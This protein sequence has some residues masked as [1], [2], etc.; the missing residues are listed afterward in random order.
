MGR[1]ALGHQ[2][3]LYACRSSAP[4]RYFIRRFWMPS[5][6]LPHPLTS[7]PAIPLCDVRHCLVV[8]V[9]RADF[10]HQP[11]LM[12]VAPR[13]HNVR[14]FFRRFTAS[15]TRATTRYLVQLHDTIPG[16]TVLFIRGR[17]G[18]WGKAARQLPRLR[19]RPI[20]AGYPFSS[21]PG[22]N[23]TKQVSRAINPDF[24]S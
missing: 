9:G 12:R 4:R 13:F 19:Y 1:S 14:M 6:G 15:R 11:V 18:E 16:R 22:C 2:T 24:T 3:V 21:R 23:R 17:A 7:K 20:I 8:N 5:V 10:C